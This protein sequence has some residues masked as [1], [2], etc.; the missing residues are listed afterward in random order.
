MPGRRKRGI[1]VKE[2]KPTHRCPKCGPLW[3]E[4][5]V[6]SCP[7]CRGPVETIGMDKILEK[8]KAETD[9]IFQS[10]MSKAEKR[11]MIQG[12]TLDCC[13][14]IALLDS[15]DPKAQIKAILEIIFC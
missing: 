3:M 11:D 5:H 1:M 13:R 6:E 14:D 4:G 2:P 15:E 8:A 7:V 10:N 12:I 9:R